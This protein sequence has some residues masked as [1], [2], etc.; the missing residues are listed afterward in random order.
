MQLTS[1]ALFL[2]AAVSVS[3]LPATLQARQAAAGAH[4]PTG[5]ISAKVACD[6]S[7]KSISHQIAEM[8]KLKAS[9][10][11]VPAYLAGYFAAIDDERQELGC[12]GTISLGKREF[13]PN[14]EPCDVNN[15]LNERMTAVVNRS[16]ADQIA[17]APFV[18]GFL[19]AVLDVHKGLGCPP[20]SG[21]ASEA[22][23][24]RIAGASNSTVSDSKL[25]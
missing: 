3:A 8:S 23:A 7:N 22:A 19:S 25:S 1:I 18:A 15:G 14:K 24:A 2:S 5:P 21:P 13:T 6:R 12:P 11:S 4:S 10:I 9:N 16:E 17:V 20:F